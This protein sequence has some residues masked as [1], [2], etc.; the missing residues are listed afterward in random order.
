MAYVE[1]LADFY[2]RWLQGP[3]ADIIAAIIIVLLG[4]IIG[5]LLGRLTAKILH[6]V[7]L[8][9]ILRAAGLKITLEKTIGEI[10]S[11]IV[12]FVAVVTAL[13]QF[14]I[15]P[16]IVYVIVISVGAILVI[17]ILIA[18]KDFIPNFICGIIIKKKNLLRPGEKIKIGR[19]EGKIKRI[20]MVQVKL[21][22][23]EGDI[24]Y[25]PNSV[26]IKKNFFRIKK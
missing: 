25:I 11:Y 26:I 14:N 17:S 4:F 3:T 10:V 5:K 9:R 8:N 19:T 12:Y 22:T 18:I 15:A 7:E 23:K 6:E 13:Y 2:S 20:S 21:E 1:K 16:T 24:V